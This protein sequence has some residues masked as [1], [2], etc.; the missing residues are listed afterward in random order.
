MYIAAHRAAVTD[1]IA[2]GDTFCGAFAAAL[3]MNKALHETVNY[4]SCAAA[5]TITRT[6]AQDAIPT[7]QEI[8]NFITDQC[9]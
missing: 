2:A 1:T 5:I 9:S 7:Q 4:A 8:V 6:G 3:A